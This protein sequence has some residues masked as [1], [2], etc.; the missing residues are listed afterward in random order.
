MRLEF[1][2]VLYNGHIIR[3]SH[4]DM[5]IYKIMEIKNISDPFWYTRIT[6]V[7]YD[8]SPKFKSGNWGSWT[9]Q[10][11]APSNGIHADGDNGTE[12]PE[13]FLSILDHLASLYNSLSIYYY[14]SRAA[15]RHGAPTRP[16]ARVA[17][18][19]ESSPWTVL[20]AYAYCDLH[21]KHYQDLFQ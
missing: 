6:E 3:P 13:A 9:P 14:P 5:H 2:T 20:A 10:L 4:T 17:I 11:N 12:S 8:G 16:Q 15:T 7:I 19:K 21:N 18:F 1:L